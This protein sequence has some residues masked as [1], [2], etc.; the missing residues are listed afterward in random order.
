[1]TRIAEAAEDFLAC[2]RIAVTG[3]SREPKEHGGNIV[4]KRLKERGYVV[5]PVNPNTDT[6]EG[7]PAYPDLSSIPGGVEAVVIATRPEHALGTVREAA[8]LGMTKVWMH[9]SFGAGSVSPEATAVGREAG[10]TVIDG[11]CPLMFGPTSDGG[12]KVMCSLL[13][14][15]GKVPRRV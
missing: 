5:F 15:T 3:V 1:M 9:R 7:D 13:K 10:M 4:Y 12:H 14:L 8:N 6:V 11:G 2:R